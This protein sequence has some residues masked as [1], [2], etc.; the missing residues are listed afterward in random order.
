[1]RRMVISAAL[2]GAVLCVA[3]PA[4]AATQQKAA[5]TTNVT[6]TM[7]EFKFKLSKASAPKGAVAFKV[8]NKGKVPHDFKISGKKTKLLVPGKSQTLT[9][10]FTKAGK[11]AYLCTVP[12]HAPSGMKGT[13]TVK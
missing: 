5:T 3:V 8:T 10:T 12:G 7:T 1:M 2:V 9:V 6:V 13:F 4:T 11:Q